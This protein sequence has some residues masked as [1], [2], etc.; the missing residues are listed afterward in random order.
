MKILGIIPARL[1]STRLPEKLLLNETGKSVLQHTWEATGKAEV[2]DQIFIAVDDEKLYQAATEFGADVVMTGE[3]ASG[4]D[5]LAEVI[6]KRQQAGEA[7]PEIVV[8]IQGDEPEIDAGSIEA[9]V[10]ELLN[11]PEAQMATLSVPVASEQDLLNSSVVKVVTSL[12]GKALYFSRATLPASR[13]TPVE[14]LYASTEYSQTWQQHIGLY[15]YRTEFLL[16]FANWSPTPLEQL[17]K[18]EQLRALENGAWIQVRSVNHYSQGIDTL[19]DYVSF[20]NRY[21]AG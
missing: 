21:N 19:E 7:V 18:L 1:Q 9:V 11:T 17:E 13:E 8:N 20:V 5:R 4:T 12:T 3:C 10:Q 16:Q 2:L 14:Q 6:R 15:A